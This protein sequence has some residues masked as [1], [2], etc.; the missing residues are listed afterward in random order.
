MKVGRERAHAG[1]ER[2]SYGC[3]DEYVVARQGVGERTVLQATET[4][5]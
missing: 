2:M 3:E 5:R 1:E 4:T